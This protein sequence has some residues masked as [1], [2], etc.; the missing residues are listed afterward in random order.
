MS[1]FAVTSLQACTGFEHC[2]R[3][4]QLHT[5]VVYIAAVVVDVCVA[6]CM[7]CC[8]SGRFTQLALVLSSQPPR[9][10]LSPQSEHLL[11]YSPLSRP[12]QSSRHPQSSHHQLSAHRLQWPT[13]LPLQ[14]RRREVLLQ[15]TPVSV[16]ICGYPHTTV[17]V[18][19]YTSKHEQ[20]LPITVTLTKLCIVEA[21]T[22]NRSFSAGVSGIQGLTVSVK[23]ALFPDCL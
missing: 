3:P 10:D 20:W 7:N 1:H 2:C 9:L 22:L 8:L 12:P 14:Q 16:V 23:I 18:I 4:L 19:A 5:P 17:A 15:S 6:S 11:T 13:P 21:H